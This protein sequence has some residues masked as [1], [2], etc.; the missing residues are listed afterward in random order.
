MLTVSTF[1]AFQQAQSSFLVERLSFNRFRSSK[2]AP[3][4]ALT[5][6]HLLEDTHPLLNSALT[7]N[8]TWLN[9]Q[10]VNATDDF[11]SPTAP[12]IHTNIKLDKENY[13]P[14]EVVFIEV[15]AFNALNKTPV[16][17]AVLPAN[18]TR[19]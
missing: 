18:D 14:R 11:V 8:L 7:Y 16:A 3:K 9:Q 13:R 19:N 12:R 4:P 5:T 6:Q 2:L 17:L 15:S 1:S 10:I